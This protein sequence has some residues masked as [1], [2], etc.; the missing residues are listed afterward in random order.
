MTMEDGL[1]VNGYRLS[2]IGIQISEISESCH[3]QI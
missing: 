3:Y 2:V 1:S